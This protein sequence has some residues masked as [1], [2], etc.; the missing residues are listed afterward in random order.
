[1]E[2]VR[3]DLDLSKSP[4]HKQKVFIRQGERN[5]TLIEAHITDGGEPVDL[6]QFEMY[7]EMRHPRG[8]ML[9]DDVTEYSGNVLTYTV[10]EQATQETG[11][12]EV[13]YFAFR[14]KRG[15][16]P[17][18]AT[19]QAFAVI[20]LPNAQCDKN[21][22]AEAYSSEIERMLQWCHD[23][24]LANEEERDALVD[25]ACNKAYEA[26]DR[27]NE[28]AQAVDDAVEGK[29]DGV[30]AIYLG[31]NVVPMTAED[32]DKIYDG[33]PWDDGGGVYSPLLLRDMTD[34]EV[35]GLFN[36]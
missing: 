5:A 34:E 4:D 22:V 18:F 16:P 20:I 32:V 13:A 15:D 28:A 9:E 10:C 1:M 11:T 36:D 23:T 7:F 27:A 21:K 31:R 2:P 14:G 8:A 17:L 24:F 26:A 25:A 33:E 12:V 29:L 30:F 35:E 6:S 19:T 3:L